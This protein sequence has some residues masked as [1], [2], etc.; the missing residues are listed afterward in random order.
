MICHL[1][2]RELNMVNNKRQLE[3]ENRLTRLEESL[4]EVKENHLPHLAQ[5]I[6]E[7]H[8]KIDK[9]IW[10]ALT[11]AIGILIDLIYKFIP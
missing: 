3:I 10:L 7:L 8:S 5:D 2:V 1:L 4:N 11:T 6:K 9:G